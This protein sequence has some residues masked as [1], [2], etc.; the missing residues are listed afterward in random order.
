MSETPKRTYDYAMLRP[1]RFPPI[2][3]AIA[4]TIAG[5]IFPDKVWAVALLSALLVGSIVGYFVAYVFI[6]I[7]TAEEN[8][9]GYVSRLALIHACKRIAD[10]D[11]SYEE[12]KSARDWFNDLILQAKAELAEN[13]RDDPNG[14]VKYFAIELLGAR[15]FNPRRIER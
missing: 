6:S 14:T 12:A 9:P 11:Q 15:R 3:L 5:A 13:D 7:K 4:V 8:F 10:S 1:L 2:F